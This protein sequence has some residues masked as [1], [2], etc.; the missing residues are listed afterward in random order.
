M[1]FN[2]ARQLS[3]IR[4][5]SAVCLVVTASWATAPCAQSAETSPAP[6]KPDSAAPLKTDRRAAFARRVFAMTDVVLQ[7][8][9]DPPT[10]QEMILRGFK[11]LLTFSKSTLPYDLSARVSEVRTQ[12]ELTAV[13]TRLWPHLTRP[14]MPA[15]A[16][17][18]ELERAF[19]DGLLRTAP[20]HAELVSKKEARVQSQIQANRYVGLGIAIQTVEKTKLPQISK[21]IPGGTAD[22]VGMKAGDMIVE[23]DHQ[24]VKPGTPLV[25]VVD[26]LRGPEGSQVVVAV[27][28]GQS[29][30]PLQFTALRLPVAFT[31]VHEEKDVSQ[32]A[33]NL[34][35]RVAHLK[36]DSIMAS[37]ARELRTWEQK[38][39][40]AGANALILDLRGASD[41]GEGDFHSALLLADSLLDGKLVGS[42]RTRE[43]VRQFAADRDCLFRDWP[44]VVLVDRG[45]RGAAEWVTAALQD[46]DPPTQTRNRRAII[47]GQPTHGDDFVSEAVPIPNTDQVLILGTGRWERPKA[48]RGRGES[49]DGDRPVVMK[50]ASPDSADTV[51]VRTAFWRVMPDVIVERPANDSAPAITWYEKSDTKKF[52]TKKTALSA[53]AAS[54][55]AA[56]QPAAKQPSGPDPILKEAV[57]QL[58]GQWDQGGK[59]T[60]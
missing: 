59:K 2:I 36:I 6:A 42:M 12:D 29:K 18:A 27:L 52:D 33:K 16:V 50:P 31:S 60:T 53:A 48:G 5:V 20:G 17:E 25:N 1:C 28:R 9:I 55:P 34:P 44:L 11:V 58:V 49:P 37:T 51:D 24:P 22:Q 23:I 47:V 13:L 46:A 57:E 3:P 43:G 19:I 26:R 35:L 7:N 41:R 38:L 14:D 39:R 10:R 4:M 54:P 56:T 32:L 8:H 21:I 30:T 15:D 40:A 45:T